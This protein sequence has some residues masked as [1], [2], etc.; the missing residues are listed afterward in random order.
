MYSTQVLKYFM[1]SGTW[2]FDLLDFTTLHIFIICLLIDIIYGLLSFQF[3]FSRIKK[4]EGQGK[5]KCHAKSMMSKE[6]NERL[7]RDTQHVSLRQN[8]QGKIRE[9]GLKVV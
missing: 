4:G 9:K 2:S 5:E 7:Q 1:E 3:I 8:A 6:A